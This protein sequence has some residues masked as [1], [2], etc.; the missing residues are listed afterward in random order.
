MLSNVLKDF[1]V[2]MSQMIRQFGSGTKKKPKKNQQKSG[3]GQ[4]GNFGSKGRGRNVQNCNWSVVNGHRIGNTGCRN[5]QRVKDVQDRETLQKLSSWRVIAQERSGRGQKCSSV[6]GPSVVWRDCIKSLNENHRAELVDRVGSV[7]VC[8]LAALTHVKDCVGARSSRTALDCDSQG[9][10]SQKSC[11]Q[12]NRLLRRE[13]ERMVRDSV[14]EQRQVV[15]LLAAAVSPSCGG[16]QQ[17]QPATSRNLRVLKDVVVELSSGSGIFG[18]FKNTGMPQRHWTSIASAKTTE[19]R[20]GGA[21]ES[22]ID[23]TPDD[24]V[25]LVVPI[26]ISGKIFKAL[27][28]SGATRNFISPSCVTCTGLTGKRSD[29]FLELG[30]GQRVLSRGYVPDVLVTIA[31][32]TSKEDLTITTLLHEVDVVLGMTW[33]KSV[34][35]L[36]DWGSGEIYIPDSVSTSLIMGDW[37][38]AAIK[39]GQVKVLSSQKDLE[40]LKNEDVRAGL[41]IIKTPQFWQPI[42]LQN[43]KLWTI[44]STGGSSYCAFFR[45]INDDDCQKNEEE[46]T[47]KLLVKRLCN[48][49]ALP[50][51]GTEGAA[52]YDISS[53]QEIV[54]PAKGKAVV[55]TGLSISFPPGMYA[56]IAPRSG[57]AVKKFIDVGAGVVDSDYRGEIGVVLFNHSDSDFQVRQGDRIAQLILEK[58]AVPIVQ[59]V[60]EL[61]DTERGD[62][63]YGSTGIGKQSS[64]KKENQSVSRQPVSVEFSVNSQ[65]PEQSVRIQVVPIAQKPSRVHL[66]KRLSGSKKPH[67]LTKSD[68]SRH[69]DLVSVKRM[70][71]LAKQGVPMFLAIVRQ[72]E[73]VQEAPRRKGR[74]FR[75]T[76]CN[77]SAQGQTEGSKRKV[78][79]QYGPKKDFISVQEREQQIMAAVPSEYHQDLQEL[80]SEFRD[81]FPETLPKGRPLKRDVEHE[82]QIEEGSKPPSRPPYKLGPAE[83]DELEVQIKDLLSQGFIRPS[84]SPYGAPVLF[85]PKKDGRW[86]MCVDYRALNKATIKDK[87]PL[88]RI[89][90]LLDRL[91]NARVFSKLDLASGYHQIAMAETSI[92]KTAFR[93]N[94]GHWEFLVMPFGLCNAPATFQRLMNRVFKDELNSFILVYLD[95]ILIFSRSIEE[96]WGHLRRAL[97]RLRE[98]KLYGRLHKCEFLK[99]RVDYLGFEI[100]SEGVHASPDKVKAVVEWPRPQSVHDVRSFLGLASYYRKFIRGFSQIARPLTDV[101]K[102]DGWQWSDDQ[103]K[104]FL[105]LKAALATAPVLCLP[106]FDRQFVVTTDASD[107]AVGAILEQDFGNGLQLVAFASQKLNGAEIRYSAYERELLGIVWALSQWRHYFQSG[108]SV[109]VRTDHSPLRYLPS[110]AAVNTRV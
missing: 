71:K 103:E 92:D 7:I 36:I 67:V 107:V 58:N 5:A 70:K 47:D 37:L 45:D 85:V 99:D 11:H 94:I 90:T 105:Q 59:E 35:P 108:H 34:R 66:L 41:R 29:T 16:T 28:D 76:L 81:V 104:S 2:R 15:R 60:Q 50:K 55:K 33:L 87:F 40:D 65:D 3:H 12:S 49:A 91:G 26:R 62:G 97:T 42:K 78:M 88:P 96:H 1:A 80:V 31:G 106:N 51:R 83:Q 18:N 6:Q 24:G 93:T 54:I 19:S 86:R 4:K 48:N 109:I 21:R 75:S 57:L 38:K 10:R 20:E 9:Q 63:G 53:A 56:R 69:R 17:G 74:N 25:L 100:F 110:Q 79:K 64:S 27:V 46:T 98:A 22:A 39:V 68:A 102:A 84:S 14:R 52:G 77:V 23:R 89:D 73:I 101:T 95:D 72:R 32:H 30:N 82:I 13:K 43:K 44:S 8:N 61:G